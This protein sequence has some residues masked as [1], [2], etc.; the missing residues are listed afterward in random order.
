M[1]SDSI[2]IVCVVLVIL[3]VLSGMFSATET[4]YSSINRIRIKALMSEGNKKARNVNDFIERYD[5]MLSTVLIGNNIVNITATSLSTLL[6][7]FLLKGNESLAATLSTVVLTVVILLFG[8]ITPKMLAKKNPERF[9]MATV[10]FMRFIFVLLYPLNLIFM[11]WKWLVGKIFRAKEE[12]GITE[13][14][15]L[16]IVDEAEKNGDLTDQET[17]LISSA[18]EFTDLDVGDVLVPRVNVIA[19]EKSTP[20]EEIKKMFLEYEFSRIPVY[21][22]NIDTIIGIIHEKDFFS[23]YFRGDTDVSAILTKVVF[24]TPHMKISSLLNKLQREKVHLAIV[25]DEYGGTK[26]LV[27][28]EDILEELVGE[29]WDEHDEVV[30]LFT[31]LSDNEYAVDGNAPLHDFFDLVEMDGADEFEAT[32]VGGWVTEQMERIPVE[33]D[34]FDYKHLHLEITKTDSRRVIEV[35]LTVNEKEEEESGDWLFRKD[36]KDREKEDGEEEE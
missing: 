20:M 14:E 27:T 36:K 25:T 1:T 12:Q 23:A 6:F 22:E 21:E 29:I 15:L 18:I 3:I 13:E 2:P 11:G 7:V 8:E 5:S 4:A 34:F 32:T 35:K 24:A 26:G 30:N 9:A 28:M 10:G 16:V 19:V 17:Q 31:A 33:G